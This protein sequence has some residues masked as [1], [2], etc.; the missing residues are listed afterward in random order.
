MDTFKMDG[1]INIHDYT[2]YGSDMDAKSIAGSKL[3]KKDS[4][5]SKFASLPLGYS[6]YSREHSMSLLE[7]HKPRQ[8]DFADGI[9]L[10]Q[11]MKLADEMVAASVNHP[12][13][14]T[15]TGFK[16]LEVV[17]WLSELRIFLWLVGHPGLIHVF[18]TAVKLG[19]VQT[20]PL[21]NFLPRKL[22]WSLSAERPCFFACCFGGSIAIGVRVAV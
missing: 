9:F 11:S 2:L 19:G 6:Q 12:Q 22:K 16:W 20:F 10:M 7:L 1:L 21:V 14:G 15:L 4:V 18:T 8:Q 17:I 13:P 5:G 3:W